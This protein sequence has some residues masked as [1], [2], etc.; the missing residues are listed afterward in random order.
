MTV[1][2]LVVQIL[3]E[4]RGQEL[5]STGL[6]VNSLRSVE[7]AIEAVLQTMQLRGEVNTRWNPVTSS[8]VYCSARSP[9][10][11]EP[12]ILDTVVLEEIEEGYRIVEIG[13]IKEVPEAPIDPDPPIAPPSSPGE[14]I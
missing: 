9:V 10:N 11:V 7:Q 13:E 3:A 4:A 8:F 1:E 12:E 6:L 14:S 5:S 2:E